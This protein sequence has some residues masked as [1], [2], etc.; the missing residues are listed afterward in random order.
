MRYMGN[1]PSNCL[2][3]S[4]KLSLKYGLLPLPLLTFQNLKLGPYSWSHH[5][6]GTQDLRNH[7]WTDL[8]ALSLKCVGRWPSLL[9]LSIVPSQFSTKIQERGFEDKKENKTGNGRI[10]PITLYCLYSI[11]FTSIFYWFYS[12][13]FIQGVINIQCSKVIG[14]F[15]TTFLFPQYQCDSDRMAFLSSK[16]AGWENSLR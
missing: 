16:E 2:L 14:Y 9:A 6:F 11:Y 5:F 15:P 1:F 3:R 12:T 10:L 13:F 7:L 4:P 8:E